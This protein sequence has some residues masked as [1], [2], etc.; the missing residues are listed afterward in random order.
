METITLEKFRLLFW[1]CVSKFYDCTKFHYHQVAGEKVINDQNFQFCLFLTTLRS[2][3]SCLE[4][5]IFQYNVTVMICFHLPF[6]A[7]SNMTRRIGLVQ[8]PTVRLKK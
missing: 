8:L 7:H 4:S 2:Q 6:R 1:L 3:M 5:D